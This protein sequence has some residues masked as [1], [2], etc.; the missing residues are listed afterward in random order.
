M[1]TGTLQAQLLHYVIVLTTVMSQ[2]NLELSEYWLL[3]PP[4]KNLLGTAKM[5]Q[6]VNV[7]A[8]RSGL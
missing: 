6:Q 7:L 4:K 8:D 1:E 5:S 2:Q 3:M